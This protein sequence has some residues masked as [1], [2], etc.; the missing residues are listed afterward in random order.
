MT[1]AFAWFARGQLDRS[2]QASPAGCLIALSNPPV[3]AWLILCSWLGRPVGFRSVEGPMMGLLV[4]I[5]AASLAFWFLRIL[6][7]TVTLGPAG[8]PFLPAGWSR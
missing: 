1:T 3:A 2:W 7:A 6:G 5:V 8:L 4:S